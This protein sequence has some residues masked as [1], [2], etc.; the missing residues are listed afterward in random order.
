MDTIAILDFGSQYSQLIARRVR[1]LNVYCQL[2]PHDAPAEQVRALNP[3]GFILS[4]GP[5]SV[6][7]AGAPQLPG[8]VLAAGRPVL[9]I[10]YGMQLLAQ[11]LGGHVGA[12][13][14]REYGRAEVRPV[15]KAREGELPTSD[16]R[17]PTSSFMAWMS[18]GD[19]VDRLPPGFALAAESDNCAIA[20]MVDEARKLYGIQFHPEVNHTE[21]GRDVLR[22]FLAA[23]GARAEWTPGSMVEEALARVRA[24]VGEAPVVAAVSGGVDSSVAAALVHRAVGDALT[25][26]FVDTGMLR[27]GE[28]EAVVE[29]FR[30][31]LGARL[32]AINAAEEFLEALAGVTDP[33]QKRK[34]IGEKFIRIFE[35]EA[36][37]LTVPATVGAIQSNPT[38]RRGAGDEGRKPNEGQV[39]GPAR[40]LVQG[41][42]YPDVV[43][44]QGPER[45][46][47]AMIKTHHNV[48]GLPKDLGFELVE[49]LRFLFKDEVRAAGLALG[50]PARMVWRQPFPGPGLAVRCLG[51][52]TWE[53]LETLRAAD[54]I[55]TDELDAAGLLRP[56]AD[57]ARAATSQ[58]FAVLLPVRSVGVM[59]DYRTYQEVCALRAVTTDDFMTADWARLPYDVLARIS[60]RI[61][62][63]VRGINRVVYDISSKPPAT[64][65]WE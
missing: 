23:T 13:D 10:C 64:I 3:V 9:G 26:I 36:A 50:L 55:V 51:E 49:P 31:T 5:S 38:T 24:Q 16:F 57:G 59:G 21:H 25:C 46:V 19:K 60:S 62:N 30:N 52:I 58:A 63:E 44:S 48:G 29:A 45:Q 37:R 39:K 8:Y 32:I 34:I 43:E 41:T 33:E 4:G 20:A 27:A 1:E 14:R 15:Q 18:H 40:F 2:F 7:D 42:I 35:R 53:R 65:E 17:L 61:V 12:S 47:A 56:G 6:Y 54:K 28:P 11:A 22:S